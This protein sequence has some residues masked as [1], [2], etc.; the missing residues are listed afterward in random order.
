MENVE[1][2]F[3]VR[4]GKV[5]HDK[6]EDRDEWRHADASGYED[7]ALIRQHRL[8]R[9]RKRPVE[10][11]DEFPRHGSSPSTTPR[12]ATLGPLRVKF[13]FG[14]L[15]V[16]L[17]GPV[18]SHGDSERKDGVLRL[19]NKVRD[20]EW[21]PLDSGNVLALQKDELTRVERDVRIDSKREK[22]RV[23]RWQLHGDEFDAGE[24]S[25]EIAK[26]EIDYVNRERDR[27][28]DPELDEK[29]ETRVR[30]LT[31]MASRR[32]SPTSNQIKAR[33]R[34]C[35]RPRTRVSPCSSLLGKYRR[36]TC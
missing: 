8:H 6:V 17:A 13:Q 14:N 18:T 35:S 1:K 29:E 33:L 27:R 4:V 28:P 16:Q 34:S 25:L 31:F 24:E 30:K 21:M 26:D 32:P 15:L 3:F 22:Y 9:A 12:A 2:N 19:D 20:G 36:A 5:S 23:A 11:E 10:N 7:D